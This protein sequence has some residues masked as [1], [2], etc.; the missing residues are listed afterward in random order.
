MR[1]VIIL[2]TSFLAPLC[3]LSAALYAFDPLQL[4][5]KP[6]GRQLAFTT[7]SRF[8]SAGLL[9]TYEHDGIILG[10]SVLNNTSPKEA[11]EI[12]GG[13]FL[14]ISMDGG[15]FYERSFVLADALHSSKIGHV[16]YS[17]DWLPI[18][19]SRHSA[20]RPLDEWT[21]LYDEPFPLRVYFNPQYL[22]C[23]PNWDPVGCVTGFVITDLENLGAWKND[24]LHA[25]R[26]GGFANWV[27]SR[28]VKQMEAV[29]RRVIAES[30]APAREL[31]VK[32]ATALFRRIKATFDPEVLSFAAA[33]PQTEFSFIVPPCFRYVHAY[34]LK[35]E[36]STFL[37][38]ELWLRYLAEISAEHNNVSVYAFDDFQSSAGKSRTT[39]TWTTTPPR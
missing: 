19:P 39:K 23:L 27:K 35:R 29:F 7:Q 5:H 1:F 10:S 17:L 18:G 4:F 32:A 13:Q 14:N 36:P 6:W 31:E 38:Y 3:G 22:A 15:N 20:K 26:F 33:Y 21:Y 12:L 16:I 34:R 25:Q 9:R 37:A 8:Q 2:L 30:Q 24:P 11:G 28:G